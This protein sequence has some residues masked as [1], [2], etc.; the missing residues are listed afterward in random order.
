MVRFRG[1][2]GLENFFSDPSV[3]GEMMGR[4]AV[5]RGSGIRRTRSDSSG[6]TLERTRIGENYSDSR[7]SATCGG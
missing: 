3:D 5:A 1:F 6:L 7:Y 4:H 2:S